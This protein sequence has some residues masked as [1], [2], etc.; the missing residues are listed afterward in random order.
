MKIILSRKG[1]DS[2]NGG[3]PSPILPDGRLLSLPIPYSFDDI[4]YSEI[5]AD[6]NMS[7]INLVKMLK[8]KIV[9]TEDSKCHL[10]PDLREEVFNRERLIGW[11]PIFGQISGAQT[12]LANQGV[13]VGD[14]FLFFG[15]FRKIELNKETIRF[16]LKEP[17]LHVIYGYFEIGEILNIASSKIPEWAQYHPHVKSI[18]RRSNQT[19]TLYLASDH[20]TGT[21]LKGAGTFLFNDELVL[22]K[23]GCS[24]SKWLLPDFFKNAKI[25]CHSENSWKDSYF[26]SNTI[27]QEFVVEDNE[28]ISNWAIKLIKQYAESR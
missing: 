3:F 5:F 25:S 28:E 11:K 27:G 26:Q 24:R 22:T 7:Y 19:N 20:L 15:W 4:S 6:K 8:P 18:E 2:K 23:K 9:L 10:D 13:K 14:L 17:N 16:I 21:G 1:F 12:H